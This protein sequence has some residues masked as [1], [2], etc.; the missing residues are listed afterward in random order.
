MA[1][2]R[3]IYFTILSRFTFQTSEKKFYLKTNKGPS[4]K[5]ICRT[6]KNIPHISLLSAF[7]LVQRVEALKFKGEKHCR[8]NVSGTVKFREEF[9]NSKIARFKIRIYLL[10]NNFSIVP[11]NIG[12]I[13]PLKLSALFTPSTR[14]FHRRRN[15]Y[16]SNYHY[17]TNLPMFQNTYYPS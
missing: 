13:S 14:I 10:V 17:S 6:A 1:E 8:S 9:I 16:T 5:Q 15:W 11:K 2:S 7:I 12:T 4:Q 3:R